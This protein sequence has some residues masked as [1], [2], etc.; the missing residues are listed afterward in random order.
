MG[1]RWGRLGLAGMVRDPQGPALLQAFTVSGISSVLLT[2]AYLSATGYPQLGGGGFH[3]AHV[4]WGGLGM[5]VAL[6][7]ALTYL[8]Q[9]SRFLTAVVG[10]VGFGLFIDEVGK[11]VTADND[12]FYRP[13]AAVIYLVFAGL[14]VLSRELRQAT[15]VTNDPQRL[16]GALDLAFDGICD[17]LTQ[18]RRLQALAMLGPAEQDT[19]AEAAVRQLLFNLPEPHRGAT[20]AGRLAALV[21]RGWDRVEALVRQ[22]WTAVLAVVSLLLQLVA[23]LGAAV[24]LGLA[25]A[26]GPVLLDG[27]ERHL[28]SLV[29]ITAGSLFAGGFAVR[30][31]LALRGRRQR[32]F[33]SFRLAVLTNILV[34]DVFGFGLFQFGAVLWVGYDLLLWGGVSAELV[35]LGRQRAVRGTG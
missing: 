35:R 27:G 17:G 2:R 25:L 20:L 6:S 23:A 1:K 11:F 3:L 26:G 8:G 33:A 34:T 4:L 12:Y 18:R 31:V 14:V 30:G 7:L 13:A 15:T 28:V 24:A 21:N 9:R 19:P 10:G 22:E 5:L 29:G 16:A 32:A